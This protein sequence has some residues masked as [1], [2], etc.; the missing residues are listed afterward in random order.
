MSLGRTLESLEIGKSPPSK[1][2]CWAG[3]KAALKESVAQLQL[4]QTN[5][6]KMRCSYSKRKDKLATVVKAGSGLSLA[7]CLLKKEVMFLVNVIT[8]IRTEKVK[9]HKIELFSSL[10]E[11]YQVFEYEQFTFEPWQFDRNP[12]IKLNIDLT[13][14]SK[15]FSPQNDSAKKYWLS[16]SVL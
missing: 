11:K 15:T 2:S 5:I 10:T 1:G 6:K 13:E 14:P 7:E 4:T 16:N 3:E 12:Q 8:T 9:W